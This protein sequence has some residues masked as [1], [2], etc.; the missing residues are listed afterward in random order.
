MRFLN[1]R[2][3]YNFM[4]IVDLVKY[5]S[6]CYIRVGFIKRNFVY[7]YVEVVYIDYCLEVIEV[8]EIYQ[9]VIFMLFLLK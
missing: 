2:I 4:Y 7:M 6:Q 3:L 1:I 8:K 9:L 5:F